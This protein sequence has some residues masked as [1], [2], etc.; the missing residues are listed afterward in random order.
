MRPV[1]KTAF[2]LIELLVVIAIIGI[3]SGLIVVTMSGVTARASIAKGQVFSNSLRNAL[4]LNLIAE[5]KLDGNVEDSWGGHAVGST[6]T[7]TVI[8]SCVQNSCYSFDGAESYLGLDDASDLRLTTGGTISVWIYPM[9]DGENNSGRMMD[10][11]SGTVG[12]SGYSFG[13]TNTKRLSLRI[14]GNNIETQDNVIVWNQWQLATVT[15]DG[16]TR[17]I[18]VNGAQVDSDPFAYLPP[19]NTVA[20]RIGNRTGATDRTFYGYIDELRIYN[21]VIPVSQIKGQYYAGLN[22]LLI[23]GNISKEKY[24]EAIR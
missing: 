3:L 5:Y 15:F 13:V 11:S 16:T 19:N 23:S 1:I 18:Y 10:K 14:N 4:M 22:N 2:T 17:K 7:V 24:I 21:T 12:Q 6:S 9:S 20:I 8:S